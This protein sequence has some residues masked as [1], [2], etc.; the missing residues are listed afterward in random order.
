MKNRVTTA[1]CLLLIIVINGCASMEKKGEPNAKG[2]AAQEQ[3][4]LREPGRPTSKDSP[5][6]VDMNFYEI[7]IEYNGQEEYENLVLQKVKPL[8]EELEASGRIE[9]FHFI[10][11]GTLDLRLSIHSEK[12]LPLLDE[13]ISA[14]GLSDDRLQKWNGFQENS[15]VHKRY[16]GEGIEILAKSLEFNSRLAMAIFQYKKSSKEKLPDGADKLID[17]L[18]HQIVHY[19]LIQQGIDN[20]E[21]IHF[22]LDDAKTWIETITKKGGLQSN[23]QG[24]EAAK[25]GEGGGNNEG[26]MKGGE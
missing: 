6:A 5:K 1:F 17:N 2:L 10:M 22:S 12:D 9:G 15:P 21:Q 8:V 3:S 23:G 18:N 24:S 13:K 11:H 26:I 19:F 14:S 20:L 7:K 25:E 4:P 16:G